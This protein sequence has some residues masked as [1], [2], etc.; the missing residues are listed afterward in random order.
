MAESSLS[1]NSASPRET[2]ALVA[3]PCSAP[4][5]ARLRRSAALIVQRPSPESDT[6]PA[7]CSSVGV[8][9][10]RRGRQVEQ[11]GR[12]DAAAP[13][14]FG[15]VGQVEVVLV[16]LR[17]CAA[18]W[19]RRRSSCACLPTLACQDVQALGVGRHEA[20]LDA[21]V[22]HFD[23][24]AGAVG[25]AVQIAVFGRAADLLAA[26]RARDAADRR[27]PASRRSGRD[28]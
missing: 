16:M 28:A 14:D 7:K 25:P 17:D 6:R 27:A 12:D 19:S 8:F 5:P 11:P 23:E 3:G 4:A 21:V 26:G 10:Q 20:V 24:V 2:E 22:H 15:D 1:A 18:A 13:P 9:E